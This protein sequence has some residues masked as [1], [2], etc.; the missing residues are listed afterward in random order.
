MFRTL[1][2]IAAVAALAACFGVRPARAT[3][4]P[5]A[6][7]H[8]GGGY[9]ADEERAYIEARGGNAY[10]TGQEVGPRFGPAVFYPGFPYSVGPASYYAGA[11]VYYAP[12]Y[13]YGSFSPEQTTGFYGPAE[14]DNTAV[15]DVRLP[16]G[17]VIRFGAQKTTSTGPERYFVS[18]ALTPSKEYVYEVTARWHE[19]AREVTRT[20]SLSVRA[21]DRLSIAF[22][23]AARQ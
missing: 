21:G 13:S 18:P 8:G 17:A 7:D 9:Y 12:S 16:A 3:D 11:S 5:G 14:V 20:R 22:V 15:I 4:Y 23:P 10:W 2:T 6:Y 19:G 1:L